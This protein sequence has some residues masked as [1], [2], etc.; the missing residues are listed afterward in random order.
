MAEIKVRRRWWVGCGLAVAVIGSWWV[1]HQAGLP[2][3]TEEPPVAAPAVRLTK[4]GKHTQ[5]PDDWIVRERAEYFDPTPLFFP[6]EWNYAQGVL[7]EGRRREPGQVFGDVEP[8]F[9]SFQSSSTDMSAVRLED[10]LDSGNEVPFDGLGELDVK[11]EPLAE[12]GGF[13]EVKRMQDGET[14]LAH[15]ITGVVVPRVDF[16]PLEFLV[17]IGR[18]GMVAA[19]ALAA[20]SG[21]DDVDLFFR[22]YLARNFRVGEGIRPG[23]YRVL[24]G[25]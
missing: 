12:R 1:W 21:A 16:A 4:V 25:P 3:A 13:L 19:P 7:L 18:A 8:K 17:V 22:S 2:V 6:T 15:P 11:V 23:V 10:V 14:I 9:V 20:G 5:D 24:I